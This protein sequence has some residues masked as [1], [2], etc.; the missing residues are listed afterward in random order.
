M[1]EQHEAPGTDGL[2]GWRYGGTDTSRRLVHTLPL[3]SF[4]PSPTAYARP[5]SRS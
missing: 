5:G 4:S 3:M 1:G 2:V